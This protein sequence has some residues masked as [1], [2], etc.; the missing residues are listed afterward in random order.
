MIPLPR[1]FLDRP[2]AHRALHDLRDGRPENSR[3]AA[4][5]A[6]EMGYGIEVDLQLSADNQA[7]VFHDYALNRLTHESGPL[8]LRTADALRQTTL[9]GGAQGI[10]TLPDLLDLV[11]GR[12]P[13]LLELKDQ[14]GAMGDNVGPLER[15]VADA[16]HSYPGLVAVMSFNPHSVAEMARLAPD[17]PRGLTTGGYLQDN[18]QII[19]RAARKRL[20][21]IPD[22]AITGASFISHKAAE[23]NNSRV[24]E[25]KASGLAVLCWTVRSAKEEAKAR[26]VA[27]NIT[28]E[29]YLPT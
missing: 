28:F 11:G 20:Q 1:P 7:M 26:K 5:A 27:D 13:V 23:L 16:V 17:I 3:A 4:R 8:R 19:P 10:P 2:L 24:A 12:I 6:V 22:I 14:D 15:A 18:W 25:I 21:T 29:G 9:R